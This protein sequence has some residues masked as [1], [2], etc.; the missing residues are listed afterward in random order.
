MGNKLV[1][2]KTLKI[3]GCVVAACLVLMVGTVL[4]LNTDTFQNKLLRHA[5][6][7]LSDKLQTRVE[8]DSISIGLFSQKVNLYGLEV[9]DLQHRKMFQ[10]DH[11]A[12]N[13]KLL[14]LLHNEVR[15]TNASIDGVR[16]Q[17]YKP[18]PDSAANYQF[19]IDAF[20]KDSTESREKEVT[21]EEKKKEKLNVN[22]TKLSLSRVDIIYNDQAYKLES[23]KYRKKGRDKHNAT[24]TDLHRSW[25]SHTKK[26][27]VDNRLTIGSVLLTDNGSKRQATIDGI[28]FVT[29]NHQPRKNKGKPKRG[30][31]DAG[32]LDIEA[33]LKA[34][35]NSIQGDSIA[36]TITQCNAL[37]KGSGLTLKSLTT[38]VLVAKGVATFNDV[39]IQMPNTQLKIA[40]ATFQLPN[41]KLERPLEFS[42]SPITGRVLLKD[43][44][45][46]FSP[47]LSGF[48]IPLLL[49]VNFS[50]N[51]EQLSFQNV[52]VSTTDKLLTISANGGI[53]GL[54]D[55]L[56]LAVRFHVNKMTAKGNIK[57][58]II[59]QFPV[60]KFMMKQL[61]NLGTI[62]YTGDFS[63]LYKK[64][65]FQ[66]LL[67]TAAGRLNVNINLDELNKYVYGT[68]R[69]DSFMLGKVMEMP[70]LGMIAC[71][72]NFK[73]DI[74][75]PRTAK[76]RQQKG[77]KLPI[78]QVDAEVYEAKYKKVKVRNVVADMKSDGAVAE[79]NITMKGGRI[80]VLCGFSFTNTNEMRKTKIKPGIRFHKLSEER[81]AEKAEEKAAKR[82]EKEERK[83]Q[84][85]QDKAAKKAAKAEAKAAKKAEREA[86]KQK[87]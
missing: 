14:P 72:A 76:M 34:D 48:T 52:Y 6:S 42:T 83:Q 5:T 65:T 29:D 51:A 70:D 49:R 28:H 71:K 31:F 26:G 77:G 1:I 54:K 10:L 44:A 66:G 36:A 78:G 8:I 80:D 38:K 46:P 22:L 25:V 27:D 13:V 41:K 47:V 56:Q 55:K 67:S 24:I 35:I 30:A 18:R 45:R 23:L 84:K 63:V 4:V 39:V 19:V 62:Y 20:K 43:I 60:K 58:R 82:A 11:L 32:H 2:I 68:A 16:A 87:P 17:L 74:S 81:K 3:L 75:K 7:L 86:N 57:E 33:A 64:E 12:V 85:A 21:K 59:N 79:G 37:D 40:N 53:T 69:T 61:N 9:E 73:F 15:I 50:G